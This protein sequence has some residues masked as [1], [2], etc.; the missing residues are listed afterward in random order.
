[1]S[2]PHLQLT[3]EVF[4]IEI[5]LVLPS[6]CPHVSYASAKIV[7]WIFEFPSFGEAFYFPF[8]SLFFCSSCYSFSLTF[9]IKFKQIC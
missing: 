6:I 7:N 5:S 9:K 4:Y 2:R 8:S 1:M 3:K